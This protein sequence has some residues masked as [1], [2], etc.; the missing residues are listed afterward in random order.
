MANELTWRNVDAPDFGNALRG[1]AL[2]NKLLNQ[3]LTTADQGIGFYR[4]Q[5]RMAADRAI[6]LRAAQIQD[7]AMARQALLDRSLLGLDGN[8]A[9]LSTIQ[10]AGKLVDDLANRD[11]TQNKAAE[12]LH[13]SAK[14]FKEEERNKWVGDNTAEI[15]KRANNADDAFALM[16]GAMVGQ[17]PEYQNALM[18]SIEQ[19]YGTAYGG[20]NAG[21]SG[22]VS[23]SPATQAISTAAAAGG[24][25]GGG[26]TITAPPGYGFDAQGNTVPALLANGA[27]NPLSVSAT[28]VTA[29]D[30][31]R[32]DTGLAANQMKAAAGF[33]EVALMADQRDF[34]VVAAEY[35]SRPG[36]AWEGADAYQIKG[37][38][39][40]VKAQLEAA[41]Y[42]PTA[43]MVFE[44]MNK[45]LVT[46]ELGN[47][48]GNAVVDS[49]GGR[50]RNLNNNYA[51]D[52][53][54]VQTNINKLRS[55]ESRN[56]LY[57]AKEAD[58]QRQLLTTAEGTQ[59]A[60]LAKMQRLEVAS[61]R[62]SDMLPAYEQA[63]AEYAQTTE[64]VKGLTKQV[65]A[66]E[67]N[68]PGG[69]TRTKDESDNLT[70]PASATTLPKTKS[71][72][73]KTDPATVLK[74]DAKTSVLPA[75]TNPGEFGQYAIATWKK[76][77][78][79]S[80]VTPVIIS[81]TVDSKGNTHVT[82]KVPGE[83][84]G[85][86]GVT[87][88]VSLIFPKPKTRK[89]Q[90]QANLNKALATGTPSPVEDKIDKTIAPVNYNV[91]GANV[92]FGGGKFGA[93]PEPMETLTFK[94]YE[95]W[96]PALKEATKKAGYGVLED[97]TVVGTTAAGI[98]QM[99][100]PT[101]KEIGPELYDDFENTLL[102]EKVQK[103]MAQH[104]FLTR[105]KGDPVKLKQRWAAFEKANDPATGKPFTNERLKELASDWDKANRYIRLLEGGVG[106][107]VKADDVYS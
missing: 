67:A 11:L 58:N 55:D 1:V 38:F 43:K 39:D 107:N 56:L 61:R 19:M 93:P 21:A 48:L 37:N 60:A 25:S 101:M 47:M 50:S 9:S 15:Y 57:T 33:D 6:A 10:N 20:P 104:L 46:N 51:L 105:V 42:S 22:V 71:A 3:A 73:P 34:D 12:A 100:V 14:A 92:V 68:T 102:T 45:S 84:R 82:M 65:E 29:T 54:L 87:E 70:K 83:G 95:D 52:D 63:K 41:G 31:V 62:N 89:K 2:T 80:N 32:D 64:V 53:D 24:G 49:V 28:R 69:K 98:Y 81:E 44:V 78:P 86:R 7:P 74:T 85:K 23:G 99:N 66:I 30:V 5:N 91:S 103:E 27:P 77:N 26:Q 97:G 35:V 96:S 8:N 40:V 75:P 94:Q 106:G 72:T 4:D 36:S 76:G 18:R 88:T 16:Q 17:S 79:N 13:A 59:A 90:V